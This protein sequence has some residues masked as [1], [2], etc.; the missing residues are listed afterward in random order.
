[1]IGGRGQQGGVQ[2]VEVIREAQAEPVEGEDGVDGELA[3]GVQQ[4]AAPAVD[5][6]D[7]PLPGAQLVGVAQDVGAAALAADGD[8]RGVFAEDQGGA[9]AVAGDLVDQ[10]ALQGQGGFEVNRAQEVD[11]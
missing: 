1:A 8:E 6:A 2:A 5:P 10:P 11:L 3:G 7:L 9:R 4:T